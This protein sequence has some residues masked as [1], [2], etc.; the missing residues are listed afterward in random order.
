[1]SSWQ[2]TGTRAACSARSRADRADPRADDRDRAARRAALRLP[3]Y[4]RHGF[5]YWHQRDDGRLV[6]GGFRDFAA[7]GVHDRRD[8]DA[9]DQAALDSFVAELAQRPLRIDYRWPGC[10]SRHGF[11]PRRRARAGQRAR[12]GRR[13]LL[14]A[15]ER[16][17]PALRRAGRRGDPRPTGAQLA[18]FDPSRCSRQGQTPEGLSLQSDGARV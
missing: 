7:R 17:G 1:M 13:R 9:A 3:H 6:V 12:L 18:L 4:G 5:D 8:D 11:P 16:A 10:R 2:P 14:R 15:R